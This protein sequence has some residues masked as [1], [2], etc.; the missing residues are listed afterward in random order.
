MIDVSEIS[1]RQNADRAVFF[2]VLISVFVN[3]V[4][5]YWV[6]LILVRWDRV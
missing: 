2:M 1:I 5:S 6:L 3:V 4:N